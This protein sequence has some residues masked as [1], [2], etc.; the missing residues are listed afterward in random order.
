MPP[1]WR[2]DQRSSHKFVAT[3]AD[4][5]FLVQEEPSS[6]VGCHQPET[7]GGPGVIVA[8]ESCHKLILTDCWR[9]LILDY[10]F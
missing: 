2:A 9:S 7:V 1:P 8:N 5:S 4:W 6:S 10:V 3:M